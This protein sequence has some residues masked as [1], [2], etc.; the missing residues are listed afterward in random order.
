[1]A[2]LRDEIP[3]VKTKNGGVLQKNTVGSM[4]V[5]IDI[6]MILNEHQATGATHPSA[7]PLLD[8][9]YGFS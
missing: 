7:L 1:M 2:T 3:L 9:P 4:I 8:P 5:Y 6:I